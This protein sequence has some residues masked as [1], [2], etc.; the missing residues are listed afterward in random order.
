MGVGSKRSAGFVE[1]P[2]ACRENFT[3]ALVVHVFM[4]KQATTWTGV[5]QVVEIIALAKLVEITGKLAHKTTA[6]MMRNT[7]K[8]DKNKHHVYW[9]FNTCLK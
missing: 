5:F 1:Y 6:C 8:L 3:A 9:L 2:R 7:R 4:N